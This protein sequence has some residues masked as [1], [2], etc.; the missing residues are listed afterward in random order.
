MCQSYHDE[1]AKF[2]YILSKGRARYLI[3]EDFVPMIQDVINTHPG[4]SFLKDAYEFHSRYVHTVCLS[5][6]SIKLYIQ[7]NII[8]FFNR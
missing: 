6:L 5:Y 2:V 7:I 8:I 4:L 3:P 1:A